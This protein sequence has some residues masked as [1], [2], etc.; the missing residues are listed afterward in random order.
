MVQIN[1]KRYLNE[2][3]RAHPNR[4]SWDIVH[5]TLEWSK[6]RIGWLHC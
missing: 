5:C 4:T 1:S 2:S 6:D 3:H